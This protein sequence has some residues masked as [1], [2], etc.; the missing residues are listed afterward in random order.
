MI[1]TLVSYFLTLDPYFVTLVSYFATSLPYP[2]ERAHCHR[3]PSLGNYELTY[4][5]RCVLGVSRWRFS[6][7]ELMVSASSRYFIFFLPSVK[8]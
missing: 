4:L 3:Y 2:V 7:L 1:S 6:S 5:G 8:T